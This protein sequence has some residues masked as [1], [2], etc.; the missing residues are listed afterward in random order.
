MGTI[1]QIYLIS[2]LTTVIIAVAYFFFR[3]FNESRRK[4]PFIEGKL[5]ELKN[6]LSAIE[7]ALSDDSQFLRFSR[8]NSLKEELESLKNQ[9]SDI[10]NFHV[11]KKKSELLS[12][13]TAIS[14]ELPKLRERTN[15]SFFQQERKRAERVFTDSNGQDL[16]TNEQLKAVL[17]NDN[18][19]LIIAGAGSGKTRVI[20]FKVRYL[21]NHKNVSPEKI[22]LLSFSRKSAGDLVKK[23]SQSIPGITARTIHSFSSQTAG[24]QGKKLFDES[25]NELGAFV[26]KALVQ[27]LK[28]KNIFRHFETFYE[29]F[30]SDIK[31]LIFYKSLDEL[32]ADLKKVNSKLIDF[33]DPFGEIK[34]RRALKTL[35]G[36]YV[37]SVDE[38]FI[39]DFL[40]LQDIKYEYEPKYTYISTSYYPDFFLNDHNIYLEHFAITTTGQPPPY[41]DNPKKYMEGIKWK[42]KIHGENKTKMIES[43]SYLLNE[44]GSSAYLSDLFSSNDIPIR[45]LLS[46]EKVYSK[47]SREFNRVFTRFYN[48]F[49]L[50]GLSLAELKQRYT[51]SKY[52]LFL[53]IFESFLAHYEDLVAKEN[54]M[55]FN[56][57]VIGAIAKIENE[58]IRPYE[59]I[60]ID[61]FQ[62]TSNLAMRLLNG[63]YQSDPNTTFLSVGDD[64]QSIYG[65]NGSDV[66]ILSDYTKRYSGVSVQNLNS[67]FR[68]HSKVVELGKRFITKNPAQ[69]AK[70]VI[71]QNTKF[72]D[73]EI[74]FLSFEEMEQK[75]QSIPD[76]ESIFVLYRY[77]DDCPAMRGLFKNYFVM[78]RNK[79]P[80]KKSG[81]RKNISLMT[82]HASKGLEAQHVFLLFPDGIRRKFPSEIEDHFVF[83][84][85]KTNADDFPF[86]EERRLMYVGITRAEQN[87][88]FV[89]P[90]KDPNSVFWDEL[91]ELNR[92]LPR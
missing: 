20:D 12:K 56:D 55:D 51:S 34:A 65:F 37:R 89:S 86:S 46:D 85:L 78:D 62:D 45:D 84:M 53:Q 41:F 3:Q 47:I 26:I 13:I 38:R 88:Y 87:L 77:N 66:T 74:G 5:S 31:P 24:S 18:R 39:A 28:D 48:S 81:Q 58:G 60:I 6:S 63:V 92:Q 40:Y 59:Y 9:V 32:R 80:V 4:V 90:N 50:S 17:C 52:S 79:R 8:F 11:R 14:N 23:I 29:K 43:Y 49:K 57:M 36:E 70:N 35:R 7:K 61:E 42:R 76:N 2:I 27:T 75:I 25:K 30:F 83:N 15:E 71:S 22:L 64:W 73:S 91:I 54:K 33:P 19:N 68:S 21:V 1:N 44:K 69:I 16:L 67:N 10:R 82:I 72:K